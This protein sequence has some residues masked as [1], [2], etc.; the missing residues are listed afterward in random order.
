MRP[1]P[2]FILPVV[3]LAV[4]PRAFCHAVPTHRNITGQ[5]VDYW[6]QR[7]S[8]QLTNSGTA[9]IDATLQIGTQ[10]EDDIPRFL[11]HFYPRLSS[12]SFEA[13]CNSLD[14]GFSKGIICG[15]R[16]YLYTQ[17]VE[18]NTHTWPDA[19]SDVLGW[20]HA[21]YV[22]HLL[23]DLTSPAHARNDPHPPPPLGLGDPMEAKIRDFGG[24]P[25]PAGGLKV[26]LNAED[27]FLDLH[28]F[29][30]SNFFSADSTF[31]VS[32]PGPPLLTEDLQYFYGPCL[33][34]TPASCTANGRKIAHKGVRYWLSGGDK[35]YATV[36]A[37]IA[38]E[39]WQTLGPKAA[40][41]VASLIEHYTQKTGAKVPGCGACAYVVSPTSP[42]NYAAAGGAGTVSITTVGDE[43][44]WSA[45]SDV[46]WI[47]IMSGTSTPGDGTVQYTVT[48]NPVATPRTGTIRIA[49]QTVT[50]TQEAGSGTCSYAVSPTSISASSG[51]SLGSVGIT[52]L[53]GC[54][55]SATSN[56]SWITITAGGTG[57]GDGTAYFTISPNPGSLARVGTLTVA[58]QTVTITQAGITCAGTY[59]ITPTSAAMTAG[60]GG[61]SFALSTAAG[62]PWTVGSDSSWI[63]V[64]SPTSGNG[65]A[66]VTFTV[67]PNPGV[68]ARNGHI[69][70]ADQTFLITQAGAVC[71][72]SINPTSA[73]MTAGGGGGSVAV[74]AAAGCSWLALRNVPWVT[75]TSGTAGSGNGTVTFTVAPNPNATSR[76]GAL[77]IAGQTFTIEQAGVPCT[78]SIAPAAAD[79]PSSGGSANVSVTAPT[80]CSWTATSNASWISTPSGNSGN[81]N[82]TVTVLVAPN[83]NASARS[84]TATVA[85]NTFTVNQAAAPACTFSI[86][87]GSA[88]VSAGGGGGS[89]NVTTQSGCSWVAVSNDSWI[90]VTSGN[91]GSGN[92]TVTFTVA[93]NT[94]TFSRTGSMTVAGK[95]FLISQAGVSCGFSINPASASMSAGGGGGSVSVSAQGGCTWVAV[96]N[97]NWITVTSGNIGSGNGPVIF[98]VAPNTTTLGRTGTITIAGQ[99]FFVSQAG[100]PCTFSINPDSAA[101]SAGAGG[102]SFRVITQSG[103]SWVA[104]ADNDWISLISGSSGIGEGTVIFQVSPNSSSVG[105]IGS[106]SV[107]G[108]NTFTISQL[109][110]PSIP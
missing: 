50:V 71:T 47:T 93:P 51:G 26:F 15:Q 88:S 29:T 58:G 56:S 76:T 95:Q 98:T 107:A 90:T 52:A 74:T 106:I 62:C 60:G 91:L 21:G 24:L 36:D 30:Q 101:M 108:G 105:R 33:L 6:R 16:I 89:I 28:N 78:F 84:G 18:P 49:D 17:N 10:H 79:I 85:N 23:E 97:D 14:W 73:S 8:M 57:S 25:L 67:G 2:F 83:S 72:Y 54:S 110:Q 42:T 40:V 77:A 59:M 31:D 66:T 99:T 100:R 86:A 75:I 102:G 38:D 7:T 43:C 53:S 9:C 92:G 63:N 104:T 61:G 48:P 82:G 96:S 34:E 94:S 103:C 81:G 3:F 64:T 55:W 109:G 35:R 69:A 20:D 22:I 46:P 65:N 32:Q 80:G 4:A 70:A 45:I 27:Y 44:A 68:A 19:L 11:F 12:L 37:A 87:P 5:A 41:Y 13:S 39:Q 1:S